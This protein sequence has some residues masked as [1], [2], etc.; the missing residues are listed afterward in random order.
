MCPHPSGSVAL[1]E[2]RAAATLRVPHDDTAATRAAE[3]ITLAK[4]DGRP[5]RQVQADIEDLPRWHAKPA[6]K[7]NALYGAGRVNALGRDDRQMTEA[8]TGRAIVTS[9][10]A[11][12]TCASEPAADPAWVSGVDPTP[13]LAA[14]APGPHLK[15]EWSPPDGWG[16]RRTEKPTTP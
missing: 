8:A 14:R 1:R 2:R 3:A 4:R 11:A 16:R 10:L 6:G 13:A 9:F 5:G 7:M 12:Q 15:A